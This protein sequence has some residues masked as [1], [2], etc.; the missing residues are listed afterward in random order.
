M[1]GNIN[2]LF[3]HFLAMRCGRQVAMDG[4]NGQASSWCYQR[5]ETM[6]PYKFKNKYLGL[7]N[8]LELVWCARNQKIEEARGTLMWSLKNIF[9]GNGD[10]CIS[11]FSH[12]DEF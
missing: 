4:W 5:Y 3:V 2:N 6:H 10:K 8:G 1:V 12:V 9:E 7:R 11:L